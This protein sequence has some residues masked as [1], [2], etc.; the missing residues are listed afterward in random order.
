MTLAAV[1]ILVATA[2]ALNRRARAG[3]A[4][5]TVMRDRLT[6]RCMA[7]SGVSAAMALLIKDRKESSIDS[8]QEDW[9]NPEKINAILKEMPFEDGE[10]SVSI[11][12]EL[13]RLQVNA[14]VQFPEGQAFNPDQRALWD[15]LLRSFITELDDREGVEPSTIINSM[16]DWMD[17]GEGDAIT[18]LDGAETPYYQDLSPPYACPNGPFNHIGELALVKGVPPE[19]LLGSGDIPGIADFLTVHGME[20][21]GEDG[22][23]FPGRIN[24]NTA[25][26]PLLA[27][28]F[29]EGSEGLAEAA[30]EFRQESSG[31]QYVHDLSNS[32]WTEEIPGA[33]AAKINPNLTTS[34]SDF[35][36]IRSAASLRDLQS[37][38]TA[39]VHR[40]KDRK[41][42]KWKCRVLQW[43]EE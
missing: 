35:F 15:R 19:L 11:S 33:G 21:L 27:A 37:E 20:D 16:K 10:V 2:L 32:G 30:G 22:F 41:T 1:S 23:T 26:E 36:R 6:A 39:V 29:P 13:A 9:A 24:L 43:N 25:E 17:S 18:G 40:E 8:L 34:Q 14:L 28:L 31:G 38:V 3:V 4:F 12:D 42:G 7:E 5:T